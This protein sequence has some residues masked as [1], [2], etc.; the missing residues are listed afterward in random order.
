VPSPRL[1]VPPTRRRSSSS[2]ATAPGSGATGTFNDETI[3]ARTWPQAE[4]HVSV[5]EIT[6]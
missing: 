4:N 5:I 2:T 3:G 1:T 6:A